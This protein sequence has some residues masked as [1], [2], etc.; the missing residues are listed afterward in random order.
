V[1]TVRDAAKY[2]TTIHHEDRRTQRFAKN[3]D[4]K[5]FVLFVLLRRF[6]RSRRG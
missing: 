2:G 3:Q 1:R 4:L 6:V 5:N